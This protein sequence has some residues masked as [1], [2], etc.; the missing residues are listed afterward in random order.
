MSANPYKDQV[1]RYKQ[2]K[3]QIERC[4]VTLA[5]MTDCYV[6]DGQNKHAD[7]LYNLYKVLEAFKTSMNIFRIHMMEGDKTCLTTEFSEN[8]APTEE[9]NSTNCEASLQKD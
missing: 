3:V 6:D 1:K 8:S 9:V 5:K 4:E 2:L 7:F